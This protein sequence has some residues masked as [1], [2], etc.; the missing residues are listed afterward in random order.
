MS[1]FEMNL[2]E[3]T[4]TRAGEFAKHESHDQSTHGSWANGGG[5][6]DSGSDNSYQGGHQ[7]DLEGAPLHDLTSRQ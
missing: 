2:E 7:P 1:R 4:I 6:T 3:V 5:S